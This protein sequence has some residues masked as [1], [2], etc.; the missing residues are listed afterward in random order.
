[1]E[2]LVGDVSALIWS[3]YAAGYGTLWSPLACR[4][5]RNQREVYILQQGLSQQQKNNQGSMCASLKA[6]ARD[7]C[8]YLLEWVFRRRHGRDNWKRKWAID[9]LITTAAKYGHRKLMYY[10]L[11]WDGTDL[12]RAMAAAAYGGHER[13]VRECFRDRVISRAEENTDLEEDDTIEHDWP[14]WVLREVMTSAARGGHLSIV[15]LCYDEWKIQ[16]Y[17]TVNE[18]MVFAAGN[19][20][21]DLLRF[22]HDE[23]GATEVGAAVKR[24]AWR[25][26]ASIVRLC[27][28]EWGNGVSSEVMGQAMESAASAGHMDTV[29]LCYEQ[30]HR[31]KDRRLLTNWANRSMLTAAENGHVEIVR[32]CYEEWGATDVRSAKRRAKQGKHANVVKLCTQ[33]MDAIQ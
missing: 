21:E 14:V 11:L 28:D 12:S 33:W 6:L 27:C 30:L 7:N 32:M 22:C 8:E 5:W 25:G 10:C 23:L 24:A 1:M 16:D 9:I 18:A 31:Y 20:H 17:N 19:G 13:L 26:H 4:Q 3:E 29:R 15:C 2:A